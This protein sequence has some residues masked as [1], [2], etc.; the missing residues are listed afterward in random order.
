M[1]TADNLDFSF[2]GL[3]TAVLYLVRE[4]GD[5]SDKQRAAV[6]EEFEHAVGD[7]V[8]AKTKR[9][10]ETHPA[11]TFVIGGGVTANRYI[12]E[13]LTRLFDE[14]TGD[15]TLMLPAPDL[16]PDNA[17]MIG[18]AGYLVHASGTPALTWSDDLRASGTL[19]V[20]PT[21]TRK[22]RPAP[23]E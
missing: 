11:A 3:K 16:S 9:A 7:V 12:R 4:L 1:A 23:H 15:T 22:E 2:S 17:L 20:D 19:S 18:M 13:R 14:S 21:R 10:L 8:V 5:L 6:A